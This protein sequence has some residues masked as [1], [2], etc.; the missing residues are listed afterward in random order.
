MEI[1]VFCILLF[2]CFASFIIFFA[3]FVM[4]CVHLKLFLLNDLG[5]EYPESSILEV[6]FKI[7]KKNGHLNI[8]F[9]DYHCHE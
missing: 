4:L 2:V 6:S 8:H 3:L 1:S 9:A 7:N 5:E